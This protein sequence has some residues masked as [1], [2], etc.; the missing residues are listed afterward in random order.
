MYMEVKSQP[1][2][3]RSKNLAVASSLEEYDYEIQYR[4]SNR[5]K[6]VDA[7]SRR[8]VMNIENKL[9]EIAKQKPNEDEKCNIIKAI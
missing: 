3:R 4:D 1:I 5:M 2:A 9:F 8:S 6:H 7:I